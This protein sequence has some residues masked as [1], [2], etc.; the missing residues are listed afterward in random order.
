MSRVVITC[1]CQPPTTPYRHPQDSAASAEAANLTRSAASIRS[2]GRTSSSH[3]PSPVTARKSGVC[4]R[5]P[6][7]DSNRIRCGCDTTSRTPRKSRARSRRCS[8]WLSNPC[9]RPV[10]A[11]L[12]KPG[13]CRWPVDQV[14]CRTGSQPGTG[15]AAMSATGQVTSRPA[16]FHVAIQRLLHPPARTRARRSSSVTAHITARSVSPQQSEAIA[17]RY[18]A[19]GPAVPP[20]TC[21]RQVMP[22]PQHIEY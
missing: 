12:C 3:V 7:A 4:S 1:G 22:G 18:P 11:R 19:E 2:A 10:A 14:K 9:S 13:R 17:A 20:A 16:T 21:R 15:K 5:G 8:A 6:D